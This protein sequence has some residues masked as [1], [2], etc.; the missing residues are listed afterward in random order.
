MPFEMGADSLQSTLFVVV[1]GIYRVS[2]GKLKRASGPAVP[3]YLF[4]E[5][6]RRQ[7]HANVGIDAE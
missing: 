7:R 3:R 4:N 1:W 5:I 6:R 2:R